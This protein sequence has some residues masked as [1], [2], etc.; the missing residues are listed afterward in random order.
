[1]RALI[2][3]LAALALSAAPAR[4]ADCALPAAKVLLQEGEASGRASR[5]LQV[6]ELA[7]GPVWWSSADPAG[8]DAF[9]ARAARLAAETDPVRLLQQVPSANNRIV[10]EHAQAWIRP[11]NCLEKLL[12]QAQDR[13]I[14]TFAEP[15]EFMSFVLRSPDARRLRVYFYT[16]NRDGIGRVTPIAEP[17]MVDRRA[18]WMLL[19]G[20]HNHNFHP[21]RPDLNAPLAPSAP[22]AQFNRNFAQEAG[23]AE[24]WITN[25]LHTARIPASAFDLFETR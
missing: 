7:D 2:A 16:V 15:T 24:A 4:A 5:L 1:M 25:G 21:G 23:M 18:G 10:T 6:W 19:A 11:A 9:R 8:Y 3:L 14:D 12:Q 20:L 17:A 13:R 22:D